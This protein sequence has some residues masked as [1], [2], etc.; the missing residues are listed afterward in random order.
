MEIS[1]K[2]LETSQTQTFDTEYIDDNLFK[3]VTKA[4]H[5]FLPEHKH[6]K[7]VDV[8]G[9]NG[10]YCDRL[11]RH[12]ND[13][14]VTLVEPD[15]YLLNKNRP[16]PQKHLIA[17]TFQSFTDQNE[18][19]DVVE[20][21]WVLHHFVSGSYNEALTLQR[22]GLEKAY[23][24]LRPGGIV[25]IFENFYDGMF[26][27]DLPGWLI[28]QLTAA[29]LL[30]PLMKRMGANTAGVGVCFHSQQAWQTML[31]QSGFTL[32]KVE[33]CYDF[34]NL[35]PLKRLILNIAKQHVG[36]LVGIKQ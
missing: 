33:H 11:L 2:L 34:G 22:E 26:A 10:L 31:Q 18:E 3:Y 9:G 25:I 17:D 27:H 12:F 32:G 5:Q 15:A 16:H 36:C 29:P 21:N 20:F 8:G 28:H 35:S 4:I 13:M 7:M 30:A 23:Q 24:V 1:V 14:D 19:F 6:L